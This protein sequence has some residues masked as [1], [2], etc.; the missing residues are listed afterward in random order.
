MVPDPTRPRWELLDT[1][2]GGER[3][4]GKLFATQADG[5]LDIRSTVVDPDRRGHGLGGV[6][7]EAAVEHARA[8]GLKIRP[9]CPFVPRYLADHP[10]HS[11]LV[12]HG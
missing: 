5:V 11:D 4:I 2:G 8:E 10:E 12:H 6:L 3:V 1:D 7:V 9:S